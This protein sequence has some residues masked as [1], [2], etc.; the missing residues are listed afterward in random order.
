MESTREKY[1]A[2]LDELE[3]MQSPATQTA[4]HS[5]ATTVVSRIDTTIPYVAVCYLLCN[6]FTSLW[7]SRRR[8]VATGNSS[9]VATKLDKV[10]PTA[11]R[12]YVLPPT[13]LILGSK[14]SLGDRK[15]YIILVFKVIVASVGC[16]LFLL[17]STVILRTGG[18]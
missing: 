7:S 8:K 3:Q 13:L 14:L 9:G 4:M 18:K 5:K 16:V 6:S 12:L 15:P 11:F 1:D 10:K 17:V 2:A